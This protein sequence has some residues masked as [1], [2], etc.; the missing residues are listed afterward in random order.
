MASS[1]LAFSKVTL[2]VIL[3]IGVCV[4]QC[5]DQSIAFNHACYEFSTAELGYAAAR[6]YCAERNGTLAMP[7][8]AAVDAYIVGILQYSG[9]QRGYWIELCLCMALDKVRFWIRVDDPEPY[10]SM[11]LDKARFWIRVDYPV[12]CLS[13]A[14]DKVRFWI[15]VDYPEPYLSMI[16]DKARFWIRVDYPVPCLSMALDKARFW[17]RVDYPEPC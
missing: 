11:I 4:S 7:R 15:R 5:P 12:P 6:L 3:N 10:L 13:M 14:L 2:A 17:I 9:Y 8:T 1:F 16:L